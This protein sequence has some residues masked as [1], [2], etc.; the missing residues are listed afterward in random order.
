MVRLGHTQLAGG[1][2]S[3]GGLAIP[4]R[5]SKRHSGRANSIVGRLSSGPT[6]TF[7]GG[8]HARSNFGLGPYPNTHQFVGRVRRF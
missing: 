1:L 6:R 3:R 4:P 5:R 7:V 2:G 8:S